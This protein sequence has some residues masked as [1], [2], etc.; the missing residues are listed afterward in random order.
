MSETNQTPLVSVVVPTYNRPEYLQRAIDTISKQQYDAVE[1]LVV[2]DHSTVP[3]TEVLS[4]VTPDVRDVSVI[5]HD[6]NRG[7]NAARNTGVQAAAGEYIAFLDD[8]DKWL[9]EKLTRQV[10]AFSDA[11]D[12]VGVVSTGSNLTVDEKTETVWLPPP[13]E[14]D[15][16]KTLLCR[17][18]VG[19]QSVVMVRSDVAKETPLDERFPRWADLEWYVAL[20]TKC[21]FERLR[22]PLVIH[23]LDTVHRIT[24]DSEKLREA[25][26]LFLE[27]YEPLAAEYGSLMVRKMRGWAAFRVGKSF[28]RTGNYVVARRFFLRAL[29][30]YPFE[31]QFYA[32]TGAALGG[33]WT[34][35]FARSLND[36]VLSR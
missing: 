24:D 13:V 1:I 7:P 4:G 6:E 28:V 23:D 18:V 12:D 22:E 9:P 5:R 32:Y 14:G 19:T 31:T 17:N 8:D 30:W 20:S 16:T 35:S 34:H 10:A 27:K 33:R 3:A 25:Y 26:R 21:E 15:L 29:R 2:D 11:G 36:T